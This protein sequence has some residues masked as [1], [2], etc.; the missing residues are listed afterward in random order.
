[1]NISFGQNDVQQICERYIICKEAKSRV[2][3]HGLYTPLSIPSDPSNNIYMDFLL[4]LP[5]TK[6]G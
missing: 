2:E 6:K 3:P 1:M 4:S 5:K